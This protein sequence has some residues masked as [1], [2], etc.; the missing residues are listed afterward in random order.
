[1]ALLQKLKSLLGL[2]DS[3]SQR[4]GQRDVGVTVEHEG[5]G[6]PS[7][8]AE[9]AVK[10]TDAGSEAAAAGTD[11]AA[12]TGSMTDPDPDTAAEPAEAAGPADGEVEPETEKTEEPGEAPDEG[13]DPADVEEMVDEAESEEA[14]SEDATEDEGEDPDL[15]TDEEVQVIKGIGPAYADRL[16]GVGVETVADL[17]V[18]DAEEIAAETDLSATRVEQWI[19]RA[20][21]R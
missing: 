17:A 12:S 10:G 6:E 19:E 20:K 7:T 3:S 15:G 13:D 21:V 14:T 11:A 1:M 9:N 8:A 16:A 18:A 5:D 4:G 2:S